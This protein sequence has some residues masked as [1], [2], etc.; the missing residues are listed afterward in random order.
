MKTQEESLIE[1]LERLV[2]R[3]FDDASE[4]SSQV[5][6]LRVQL[7]DDSE[8]NTATKQW[9]Q[10]YITSKECDNPISDDIRDFLIS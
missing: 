10:D 4:L 6:W 8:L 5:M 9:L 7:D 1:S 2:D 3:V